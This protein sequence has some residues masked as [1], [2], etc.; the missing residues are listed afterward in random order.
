[1]A[2]SPQRPWLSSLRAPCYVKKATQGTMSPESKKRHPR[3]WGHIRVSRS[4]GALD[5]KLWKSLELIT[6]FLVAWS[7]HL[8]TPHTRG[9]SGVSLALVTPLS[10][11]EV[12]NYSLRCFAKNVQ[13]GRVRSKGAP[14]P[15]CS[16]LPSPGSQIQEAASPPPPLEVQDPGNY[17]LLNPILWLLPGRAHPQFP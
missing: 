14:L 3:S 9:H 6:W 8:G 12:E 17:S 4:G 11:E 7:A 5:A 1:M 10:E 15:R 16:V 2:A 13:W